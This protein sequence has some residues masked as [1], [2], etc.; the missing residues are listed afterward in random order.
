MNDKEQK[1]NAGKIAPA[2]KRRL[3]PEQR[4]RRLQQVTFSLLAVIMILSMVVALIK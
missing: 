3:T 1:K 2:K 4:S